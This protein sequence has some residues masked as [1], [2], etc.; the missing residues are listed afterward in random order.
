MKKLDINFTYQSIESY[1]YGSIESWPFTNDASSWVGERL[2]FSLKPSYDRYILRAR[3]EF[4]FFSGKFIV[5]PEAFYDVMIIDPSTT[6]YEAGFL[7]LGK[8]NEN[9]YDE[10]I[11]LNLL[12]LSASFI[13]YFYDF[14]LN[15]HVSQIIPIYF[16]NGNTRNNTILDNKTVKSEGF[17]LRFLIRYDF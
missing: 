11:I 10:D 2:N 1:F 16:Y 15:L 7:G 13:F 3:N 5:L 6:T 8:Q 12:H 4:S 14:K 17:T 9:V